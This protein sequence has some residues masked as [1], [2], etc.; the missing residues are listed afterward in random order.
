MKYGDILK[1]E[2]ITNFGLGNKGSMYGT[3]KSRLSMSSMI[4]EL[5]GSRSMDGYRVKTDKSDIL[6]LIDNGQCCCESWGYINSE[7]DPNKFIGAALLDV[8]LTDTALN[9]KMSDE[10]RYIDAGGI[11]FVDFITDRGNFQLAVYN[12]HNGYYGHGIIVAIDGEIICQ[13]TL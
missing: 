10:S 13:D 11:Q 9:T 5:S 8:K 6:V 2:E 1:I 4:A 7:D 12:G 3:N